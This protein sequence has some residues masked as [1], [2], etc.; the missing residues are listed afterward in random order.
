MSNPQGP[1]EHEIEAFLRVRTRLAQLDSEGGIPV[2][3][4]GRLSEELNKLSCLAV[5]AFPAPPRF[6]VAA[7]KLSVK[8]EAAGTM[9]SPD[10]DLIL[11]KSVNSSFGKGEKTVKDDAYRRGR[12]ISAADIHFESIWNYNQFISDIEGI[13]SATMFVGR[14]AKLK[15]YKLAIYTDGGHFDWHMD[16]THSDKHH[17]TVLLALNTSWS[18][19]DLIL[20]R[21]GVETRA[22]MKPSL[23]QGV[24]FNA[25]SSDVTLKAVAFYTDTEHKVEHVSE[26]VRIVL[27]YDVEVTGFSGGR[28]TD[29]I[30][31]GEDED[32]MKDEEDDGEDMD[33]DGMDIDGDA[34]LGHVEYTYVK[35][36]SCEVD[37]P[38]VGDAGVVTTIIST[39]KS[40][41]ESDGVEEVG[42]AMQYLYRKSAV[43]PEFLKGSDAVLYQALVG[44]FGVSLHPIVLSESSDYEGGFEGCYVH[45]FDHIAP[46][47]EAADGSVHGSDSEVEKDD[48]KSTVFYVPKSSAIKQI[49]Y[50]EYIEHT[51]NEAQPAEYKYFGGGMF[52][53]LRESA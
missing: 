50:Q 38:V 20:R 7:L 43:L 24:D 33:S 26:G 48:S 18:G 28:S 15:F 14:D 22:D 35:R 4:K 51:G 39:I 41:L 8:G 10:V 23:A 49:S 1:Q 25:D 36:Q 46:N 3:T 13:V 11:Q 52:V 16:S 45:R 47:T 31:E 5:V 40:L 42:F 19:G 21:N 30:E 2:R 32:E 12:E 44:L 6:D 27:Q 34:M 53:R 17:A 9:A 29:R 37:F